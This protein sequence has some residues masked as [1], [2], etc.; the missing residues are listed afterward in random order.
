MFYSWGIHGGE[1]RD[2]SFSLYTSLFQI[3]SLG[4]KSP[5]VDIPSYTTCARSSSEL[6]DLSYSFEKFMNR[7][8]STSPQ[9]LIFFKG[10]TLSHQSFGSSISLFLLVTKELKMIVAKSR[11]ICLCKHLR[12]LYITVRK[13]A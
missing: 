9:S 4:S 2:M 3:L 6:E 1:S 8:K 13:K 12:Y 5:T 7:C 11:P 10:F